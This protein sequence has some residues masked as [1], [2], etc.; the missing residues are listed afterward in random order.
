LGIGL[1][2]WLESGL[3]CGECGIWIRRR[4]RGLTGGGDRKLP[5]SKGAWLACMQPF[6]I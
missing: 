1:G 4:Q 6:P 3:G 2:L 5:Y